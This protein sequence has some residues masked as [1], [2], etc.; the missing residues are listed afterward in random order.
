MPAPALVPERE[1][2][3]TA[4]HASHVVL[5]PATIKQTA[6]ESIRYNA[7]LSSFQFLTSNGENEL[8]EPSC[9]TLRFAANLHVASG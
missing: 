7:V 6:A 3:V 9:N 2:W 5:S 4:D 1:Q 8:H